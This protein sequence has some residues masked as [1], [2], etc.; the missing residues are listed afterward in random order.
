MILNYLWLI[1]YKF[2]TMLQISQHTYN[3]SIYANQREDSAQIHQFMFSDACVILHE[4][5]ILGE[6]RESIR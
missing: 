4:L 6:H 3:E 1:N 2:Q 5:S